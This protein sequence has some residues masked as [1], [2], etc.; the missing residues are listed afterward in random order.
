M[1]GFPYMAYLRLRMRAPRPDGL[2]SQEEY[3]ALIEIEDKLSAAIA[4]TDTIYVGRNTSNGCRDFYFY[5]R[6]SDGWEQQTAAIMIHF[7]AYQYETGVRHD[8]EWT[9]LRFVPPMQTLHSPPHQPRRHRQQ[10]AHDH[11]RRDRQEQLEPRPIDDD[12]PRQMK[13]MEFL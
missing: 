5:R 2:S 13:Q 6:D 1:P 9:R 4:D 8:A 10:H 12:I 11:H 3:P 7:S